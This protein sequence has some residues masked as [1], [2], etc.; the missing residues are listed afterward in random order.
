MPCRFTQKEFKLH[1]PFS[2]LKKIWM[3][4]VVVITPPVH[5]KYEYIAGVPHYFRICH[6][7]FRAAL[8]INDS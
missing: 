5:L 6:N 8:I 4:S 3:L 2:H 7:F 1:S